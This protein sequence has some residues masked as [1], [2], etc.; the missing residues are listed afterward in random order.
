M[1]D[2]PADEMLSRMD[3]PS[4]ESSTSRSDPAHLPPSVPWTNDGQT[5]AAWTL[6]TI[7]VIGGLVTGIGVLVAMVWLCWVG[8]AVVFLGVVVGKVL[9][10][11]GYGQGGANT[12]A[13]QTRA[14]GRSR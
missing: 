2:V 6:V 10:M 1:C 5:V 4:V 8:L 14:K 12:L 7:V 11:A 3:D 9:Q 13:K